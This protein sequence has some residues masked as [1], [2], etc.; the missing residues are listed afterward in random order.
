[1]QHILGYL[2]TRCVQ[3]ACERSRQAAWDVRE[4]KRGTREERIKDMK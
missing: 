4:E 2:G 1:M 3:V